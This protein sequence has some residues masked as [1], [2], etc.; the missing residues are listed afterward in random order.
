MVIAGY[1]AYL[2]VLQVDIYHTHPVLNVFVKLL[3]KAR[4]ERQGTVHLCMCHWFFYKYSTK[5]T[6]A[7]SINT[8]VSSSAYAGSAPTPPTSS[9]TPFS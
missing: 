9:V 8:I 3:E 7:L 1:K 6:E 5:Q 2:G 4:L